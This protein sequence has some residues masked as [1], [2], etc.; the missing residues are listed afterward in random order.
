MAE[1]ELIRARKRRGL[2]SRQV[3]LDVGTDPANWCRIEHGKTP[4][5]LRLFAR[6]DS[7]HGLM[8]PEEVERIDR[9]GQEWERVLLWAIR[10]AKQLDRRRAQGT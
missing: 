2:A 8:P 7:V 9:E 3:A 5:S 4:L 6:L 1:S 10:K